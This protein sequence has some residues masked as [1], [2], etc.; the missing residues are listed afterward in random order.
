MADPNVGMITPFIAMLLGMACGPSVAPTYWANYCKH[1][2]V[3]LAMIVVIYYLA[4]LHN[5]ARMLGALG[6]F[7]AFIALIGSLFVIS[8]GIH[9]DIRYS[10]STTVAVVWLFCGAIL[11]NFI[12]TT[13]A[14]MLMI[15]P[16]IS[17]YEGQ[18]F[19]PHRVAVFVFTICNVGGVSKIS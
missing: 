7:V 11:S 12:G 19:L 18:R 8:G 17:L 4:D 16:F 13:G 3:T 9:I 10:P 1:F 2:S 15:R 6:D 5:G 14:S